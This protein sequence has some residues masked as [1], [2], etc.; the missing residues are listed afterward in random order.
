VITGERLINAV[1]IDYLSMTRRLA[2]TYTQ[3]NAGREQDQSQT[4]IAIRP[5]DSRFTAFRP[6]SALV[7]L[8]IQC[9]DER[10][11]KY[12][13]HTQ[14]TPR[15]EGVRGQMDLGAAT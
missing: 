8:A 14:T 9:G 11:A 7:S 4:Q 5:E 6:S 15:E 1:L 2:W 13:P 10:L 12:N 3:E